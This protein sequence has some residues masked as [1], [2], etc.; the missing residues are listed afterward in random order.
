MALRCYQAES[1][2]KQAELKLLSLR[3]VI[4]RPGKLPTPSEI[5]TKQPPNCAAKKL[6]GAQQIIPEQVQN[7]QKTDSNTCR[8]VPYCLIN[9]FLFASPCQGLA[10]QILWRSVALPSVFLRVFVHSSCGTMHTSK[11]N[12]SLWS[13]PKRPQCGR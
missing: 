11:Y 8:L 1:E 7:K 12:I 13:S 5:D 2:S 10:S 6:R 4:T 3:F 9:F